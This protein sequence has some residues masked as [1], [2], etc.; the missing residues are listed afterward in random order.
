MHRFSRLPTGRDFLLCMQSDTSAV[1]L[2]PSALQILQDD[3]VMLAPLGDHPHALGIQRFTP[4]FNQN[5]AN[6]FNG[7]FAKLGR[8]FS[9]APTF[10][11]H[12]DIE[13]DKY[14][15]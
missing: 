9:G 15:N 3:W 12:H 7:F 13:P 8:L 5:M 10:E 11:G 1:S 4:E 6:R 2:Q 14:P